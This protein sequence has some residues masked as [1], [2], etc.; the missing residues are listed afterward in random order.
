[1]ERTAS[2][3]SQALW[4][5]GER[6]CSLEELYR[7]ADIRLSRNVP[8]GKYYKELEETL[9]KA[10]KRLMDQDL[11]YAYVFYLRYATVV[12]KHLPNQ[13]D[14]NNPEYAKS[15]ERASKNAKKAL[16]TL[17]RLQPILQQRYDEYVKYLSSLPRPKAA[18]STY[19]T[20]WGMSDRRLSASFDNAPPARAHGGSDAFQSAAR[21]DK[22]TSREVADDLGEF[23]LANALQGLD[24]DKRKSDRRSVQANAGY[25]RYAPKEEV[26]I[27]YPSVPSTSRTS[28]APAAPAASMPPA[29]APPHDYHTS[30][31]LSGA[32][33]KFTIPEPQLQIQ[34]KQPALPPRPDYATG[35][36]RKALNHN[37]SPSPV[38]ASPVSPSYAAGFHSAP[39]PL[40]K[41]VPSPQP[42]PELQPPPR[43][44]GENAQPA[45]PPKPR[46]YHDGGAAAAAAEPATEQFMPPCFIGSKQHSLTEGG[47]RMRPIQVPEGIFEEFIDIASDNTRANLETCGVLCGRQV[48]GQDALIMTTLILPKQRATSDTCTTEHEE[49]LFAEQMDRDLIT[50]GWIHTH[51][52]QTCFMSSLDLHTQCSYQ[53][54]LPEA[55][56]I[57]CSPSYQPRFGIF[58]LTDPSGIDTIQNCKEKSAFHPHD[59]SKVIY[60]NASDGSHVLLANYDFDIVDIRGI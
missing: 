32:Y 10:K 56:A 1:M 42:L 43:G 30:Q 54:M 23:S 8:I 31:S 24:L 37:V 26:L 20:R 41:P 17:E 16:T 7:A 59:D 52:S 12:V 34:V 29:T 21:K 5:P 2:M 3:K 36:P 51:P 38:S 45:V 39:V 58:R 33:P 11:Q 27:E 57:V 55:I 22:H 9:A 46:E 53:L 15:K 18:V 13:P 50:L 47:A 60:T 48:P 35:S 25:A 40:Q 28:L 44:D 49:E 19:S 14:Y 6:V 4:K